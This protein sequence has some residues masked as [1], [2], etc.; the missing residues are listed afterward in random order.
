MIVYYLDLAD[1][2]AIVT[3]VTGLDVE[4]AIRVTN[5]D[6]ADSAL[7][8]PQAGWGETDLYPA[9]EA[10]PSAATWQRAVVRRRRSW[11]L[12]SLAIGTAREPDRGRTNGDAPTPFPGRAWGVLLK[13]SPT[14][15]SCQQRTWM[16]SAVT[17]PPR[18]WSPPLWSH[19]NQKG[20][21]L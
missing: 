7:H 11:G 6:L 16:T 2:L 19:A 17:A 9:Y 15:C 12:P 21:G 3:E 10:A 18:G 4:T 8:A 20:K 5:L 1:Y 13:Q 14:A